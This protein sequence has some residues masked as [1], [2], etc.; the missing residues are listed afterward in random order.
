[1]NLYK[2]TWLS[3]FA[4]A[5]GAPQAQARPM[6]L[7]WNFRAP[8]LSDPTS[9]SPKT[10][11]DIVYDSTNNVFK[12]WNGTQFVTFGGG[13]APQWNYTSQTANY[14]ATV[15]DYVIASGASFTITLPDASMPGVAGQT[16]GIQH[17]GTSLTQLYTL[18]T[19]M[20]TQ[21]IGGVASGSYVLYTNGE[22]LTIISD[23]HNWQILSHKTDTGWVAYTPTLGAGFGTTTPPTNVSYFYKRVGD[24]VMVRGTHTDGTATAA[25]GSFTLPGNFNLDNSK[26]SITSNT[27]S[28]PGGAVGDWTSSGV[29]GASG[30]I[31]TAYGTSTSVVYIAGIYGQSTPLTPVSSVTGQLAANGTV[32]SVNFTV[33][34]LGWQP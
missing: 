19:Y 3:I 6:P 12:G 17:G 16:I 11:G 33:P 28:G 25:V 32:I 2:Y 22:T 24:S 8:S 26:I 1:M 34:V 5:L 21:T 10:E 13:A 23:G 30:R 15:N 31:V 20:G 27:T 7:D 9:I 4:I 14:S 18:D 29:T